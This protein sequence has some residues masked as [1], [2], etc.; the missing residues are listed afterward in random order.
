MA[1]ED[2]CGWRNRATLTPITDRAHTDPSGCPMPSVDQNDNAKLEALREAEGNSGPAD[3]EDDDDPMAQ[4]R[5]VPEGMKHSD[6]EIG[7]T[8]ICGGRKWRCTDIGTR[9][10]IGICLD[11]TEIVTTP[12]DAAME[13]ISRK[14]SRAEAEA[15]GWFNG[16]PLVVNEVVF[17]EY[18]FGGCSPDHEDATETAPYDPAE[19]LT[20]EAT[21][22][23]YRKEAEATNEPKAPRP[24]LQ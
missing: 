22:S 14:L 3:D 17:D 16:P 9:T 2:I 15:E 4:L 18:D 10:I 7:K 11:N 5:Y 19:F 8:F 12:R 6:F 13:A 1:G 20:D 21:I 24:K 23:A